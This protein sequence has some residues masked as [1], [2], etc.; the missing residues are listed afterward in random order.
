MSDQE[1]TT[2]DGAAATASPVRTFM[3]QFERLLDTWR[4]LVDELLVRA[5]L[6]SMEARTELRAGRATAENAYLAAKSGVSDAL[7]DGKDWSGSVRQNV[8]GLVS[9]LDRAYNNAVQVIRRAAGTGQRGGPSAPAAAGGTSAPAAAGGPS[10]GPTSVPVTRE[11]PALNVELSDA[12]VTV[13]RSV[14]DETLGD[15]SS[16]IAD[17]DNPAFREAL[18]LRRDLLRGVRSALTGLGQGAGPTKV[19]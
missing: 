4:G 17:T 14:L 2:G 15:M 11:E 10:G 1:K 3:W 9:D 13:L 19:E 7:A 6:A 8:E 5:D 16:E 12:E 18:E